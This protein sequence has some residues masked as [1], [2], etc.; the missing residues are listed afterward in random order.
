MRAFAA[1]SVQKLKRSLEGQLA[2]LV[3][4]DGGE[5]DV[6]A[7]FDS[8]VQNAK[9]GR[10]WSA[11]VAPRSPQWNNLVVTR[12][13]VVHLIGEFLKTRR[14]RGGPATMREFLASLEC[15]IYLRALT[16]LYGDPWQDGGA[17]AFASE[18][19]R[20]DDVPT[21]GWRTYARA[22]VLWSH[23]SELGWTKT[24]PPHMRQ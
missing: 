7:E 24:R 5:R 3:D 11:V 14:P 4:R 23:M 17:G 9:I 6:T 8:R 13:F 2:L 16:S 18:C 10:R 21:Y 22:N 12:F 15:P 20:V 1:L 19:R